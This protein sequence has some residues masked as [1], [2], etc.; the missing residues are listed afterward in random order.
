M[1][2]KTAVSSTHGGL[3]QGRQMTRFK[4]SIIS[5]FFA[6]VSVNAVAA[7]AATYYVAT[8]GS[9]ANT[10]GQAQNQNRPLMTIRTGVKCLS[11]G[12]TLIIK[13]GTYRSQGILNPPAGT[14]SAYT[15]I[16]GDPSG[17]RPLLRPDSAAYQRGFYCDRGE[18]CKY[19]E[20]RYLEVSEAYEGFKLPGNDK[21]GYAH[22]IN[23][24]DNIFHDT[25]ANG[26]HIITSDA[27][28]LGGD[29]LIQGNEWY[30]IGIGTPGYKP[31]WNV[32]YNPGNRTIVERNKFHNSINGIGIWR[33]GKYIENVIIRN[34]I[35][36]DMGRR[37]IDSW[38]VDGGSGVHVSSPG[39]EHQIYNNI[40]YRSGEASTFSA[41]RITPQFHANNLRT[42]HIY[43]NTVY[44]LLNPNASAVRIKANGQTVG[45]PHYIRNNIAYLAGRGIVDIGIHIASNNV[46]TDPSFKDPARANFSLQSRSIAIDAGETLG[47]VTTDFAGVR[48]PQGAG[49]DIG[50]YE[51]GN[52]D[53]STPLPP[54]GL[55]V[56]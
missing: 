38:Q 51:A 56:R 52:G 4:Q 54:Y 2:I 34:N 46:T 6:I 55:L 16:K 15:V 12:D 33:A 45:G 26:C 53:D 24:I 21:F 40:V 17:P 29:H 50:A 10:C 27:G 3:F 25:K 36:Y 48:R 41:F 14:A 30:N 8:T 19:I 18:T 22:H 23:I 9:D 31:G 43:N 44:D 47:I 35:F 7:Q 42:V 11:G 5:A 13:A 49:Y 39:G 28:Y 32:I 37:S 1:A 20:I